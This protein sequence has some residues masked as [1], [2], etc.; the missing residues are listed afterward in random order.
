MPI[1]MISKT[2]PT[3]EENK[4]IRNLFLKPGLFIVVTIINYS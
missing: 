2:N 4:H 3:V 1:R